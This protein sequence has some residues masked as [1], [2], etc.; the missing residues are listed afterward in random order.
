VE[1][2]AEAH[3]RTFV[4]DRSGELMRRAF[5]LTGGD[6]DAAKD[7]LQAALI[8]AAKHWDR[9]ADPIAYIRT[10]MY[11][12]QISWWRLGWNRHETTRDELPER[13]YADTSASTDLRLAVRTALR[14][15]TPKQRAVLFLRYFE[16]LPEAAVAA[17]LGCGVG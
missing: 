4:A 6:Q 3:F 10:T 7:L 12:Q 17:V 16:D 8:K 15:L 11:R 1:Q 2:A 14:R 13:S 5:I 9:I